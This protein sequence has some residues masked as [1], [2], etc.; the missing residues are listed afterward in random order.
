MLMIY[1]ESTLINKFRINVDRSGIHVNQSEIIIDRCINV[2]KL[3]IHTDR[4]VIHADGTGI[5]WNNLE[6]SELTI[7]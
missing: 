2:N 1:V 6:E 7:I 3:W 4:F 5:Y